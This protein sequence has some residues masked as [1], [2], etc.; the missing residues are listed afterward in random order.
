MN[1]EGL[2][3]I[4]GYNLEKL[5][6]NFPDDSSFS[7]KAESYYKTYEEIT[8]PYHESPGRDGLL[9]EHKNYDFTTLFDNFKKD[10]FD[11]VIELSLE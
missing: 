3:G 1:P 4:C 11:V 6:Y 9:C 2:L 7:D 5:Q 8:G 10:S